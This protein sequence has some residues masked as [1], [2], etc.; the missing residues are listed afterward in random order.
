MSRSSGG[1][2]EERAHHVGSAERTRSVGHH[3]GALLVALHVGRDR[4]AHTCCCCTARPEGREKTGAEQHHGGRFRDRGEPDVGAEGVAGGPS[5]LR[6]E[7]PPRS[8]TGRTA[9][10]GRDRERPAGSGLQWRYRK[11]SAG[12]SARCCRVVEPRDRADA[13]VTGA[14]QLPLASNVPIDRPGMQPEMLRKLLPGLVLKSGCRRSPVFWAAPAVD[15]VDV[16]VRRRAD[17]TPRQ[18][19]CWTR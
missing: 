15:Q 1:Q 17:D 5:G 11:R 16:A 10:S 19:G 4:R 13:S 6:V 7:S 18:S 14:V 12:R 3:E 8:R 2:S 9:C